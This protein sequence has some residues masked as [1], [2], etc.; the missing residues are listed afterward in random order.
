MILDVTPS[1]FFGH[2]TLAKVKSY[3]LEAYPEII[4]KIYQETTENR[5]RYLPKSRTHHPN[6]LQTNRNDFTRVAPPI[7]SGQS[8]SP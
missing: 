6:E 4:E 5:D 3:F 2:S 7:R 8:Q 1:I